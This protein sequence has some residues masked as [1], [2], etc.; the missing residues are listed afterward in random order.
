MFKEKFSDFL[1]FGV[2]ML[3]HGGDD[4]TESLRR[5]VSLRAFWVP[6]FLGLGLL[7]TF[8][9]RPAQSDNNEALFAQAGARIAATLGDASKCKSEGLLRVGV[10]PFDPRDIP[11]SGASASRIYGAFLSGLLDDAPACLGVI[12][13]SGVGIT[14]ELLN[15]AG[16]FR[17]ASTDTKAEIEEN[18]RSVDFYVA[19]TIREQGGTPF[20]E[21]KAIARDS[22]Q[23]VA[24][25]GPVDIPSDL[26]GGSCS[27]GAL[28][29]D[30]AMNR[31]AGNM[32]DA[33]HKMTH[34]VVDGGYYADTNGKTPFSFYL[35]DL[36]VS[37]L[38]QKFNETLSGRTL[39]VQK[40]HMMDSGN[41]INS[42]GMDI[43][44]LQMED[45]LVLTR[46]AGQTEGVFRLKFRYWI[47]EDAVRT[48]ATLTGNDGEAHAWIENIRLDTTPDG[49]ALT[50]PKPTEVRDWGPDGAFTFQMT[51][52]R[53]QSPTYRP[54]EKFETLFRLSRDAWLFCFYTDSEGETIQLLPN[55][56]QITQSAPNFYQGGKLHLFP[57]KDRLPQ[58]DPF[59]LTINGNTY[60]IESFR[61]YATS[62]DIRAD[63]PAALRGTSL[64]P[65][66]P[67]YAARLKEIF[68]SLE[69]ASISTASMTVTVI[70]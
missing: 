57:D 22:G 54:G 59:D 64:D 36:M 31:F 34:L 26:A 46:V 68:Q 27:D 2:E 55:P 43:N 61:C 41:L 66:E 15:K 23:I 51:S 29:V 70:E 12:D 28:S 50:P 16:A 40:L 38:T 48:V 60:G 35:E 14:L 39:S 3:L 9:A 13:V 65:I 69:G 58:P 52:Q 6:F 42:R 45:D 32:R 19:G 5:S 21:F 56:F 20:A 8:T 7:L 44:P 37:H 4:L 49:L 1:S 24:N 33:A 25:V 62:R 63:L 10:W 67:K 30:V 17:S 11:V 47:C 53:G 18:L